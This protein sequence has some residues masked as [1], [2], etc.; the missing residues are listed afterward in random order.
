VYNVWK[1]GTE[2]LKQIEPGAQTVSET[3]TRAATGTKDYISGSR[4]GAWSAWTNDGAAFDCGVWSPDVSTVNLQQTFTQSRT[5]S[6]KQKH[7]RNIYDV[8]AS[9]TETLNRNEVG[10]QT[11]SVTQNQSATG[12]KDFVTGVAYGAWSAWTNSGAPFGCSTW[13]PAVSTV[14]LGDAFTQSRTCTQTQTHVR[15]VFDVYKSGAQVKTGTES[16]SQNIGV[17]QN[18]AATGTKDYVTGTRTGAWGAWADSGGHY[19]CGT[20]SPSTGT[21]DYNVV[22]TQTRSCSQAQ[23]RSRTIY[24]VWKSGTETV[25]TTET[26]SQVISETESQSAVGTRD[27]DTGTVAY[28]SWSAWSNS[29]TPYSC[30]AWSPAPSTVNLG[31]SFT[32]SRNCSQNQ[33]RSR[34]VY[35]VMAS[36]Q[37]VANG[38]DTGSQTI[39]VT[40]TQ[41]S[42]GTK[43]YVTGT[44]YSAWSGWANSGAVTGCSSW[45]PSTGSVSWGQSFTQTRTCSQAQTQSRTVYDVWASGTQTVRTTESGSRTISVTESRSSTGTSDYIVS[46]SYGAWSGW[47]NS[48]GAYSC[49]GWSPATSTVNWGQAF[50]QSRSCSQDQIRSRSITN[51][52]ASGG[53]S[54]GGTDYGS[55]TV[56][57]SQTQ[58]ATGSKDY[59]TGTSYGSWSGW[60]NSGAPYSCGAWSPDASTVNYG[61]SFT[62]TRSCAQNQTQSRAVYSVWASGATTSNGTESASQTISVSQSQGA[63]GT[64]NIVSGSEN[65][66]GPWVPDASSLYCYEW[67]P[68][69]DH[70]KSGDS[71]TQS[72]Y[73]GQAFTRTTTVYNIWTDG[74]KSV[75]STSTESK[76]EN[77]T[78]T[79]VAVGTRIYFSWYNIGTYCAAGTI[80]GQDDN[81]YVTSCSPYG[82][83]KTMSWGEYCGPG[84]VFISTLKCM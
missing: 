21:Y 37:Q 14:N 75:S 30:G 9:G 52:W 55:Q 36:G 65:S 69:T 72:R 81:P 19:A 51:N 29:G 17:T 68:P 34:T 74:T 49:G 63:T 82:A 66:V 26:G 43:D 38:T 20:W 58:G 2:T 73:C 79:R 6:Q 33:T 28:G 39:S 71:Y 1:S 46:T 80:H 50:T 42:T 64:K 40:Q 47:S 45:S 56:S 84:K 60:A 11:I 3:E 23:T 59:V 4:T 10:S 77:W 53:T 78:E 7:D 61:S 62:Q 32:Q 70:V 18:Q 24:N 57:V 12:T 83:T 35:T 16:G 25:N 22:F 54:S 8:W 27:Y 44:A 41:G 5:C 67:S 76:Y 31:T 48:G 13:S 15:D